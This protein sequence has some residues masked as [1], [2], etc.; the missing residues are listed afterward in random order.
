[1][2]GLV[3]YDAA[4][5]LQRDLA[6]QRSRNEIPDT[7]LL[8]EHPPTYTLGSKSE[9]RH[10]LAAKEW[11]AARR[12]AVH[13]VDRGGAIT[14]HGPGQLV[15]YPILQLKD[16]KEIIPYLRKLEEMV[17]RTLGSF[18]LQAGRE[19]SQAG[20]RPA[21]GVWINNEKVAA[22]GVKLD[23]NN[24]TSHGFAINV[25]TDLQYFEKIVPCGLSNRAVTSLDVCLGRPI[26]ME[27]VQS[28]VQ[29]AFSEIFDYELDA[30]NQA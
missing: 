1:M 27:L 28:R 20:Q 8:L 30:W 29:Q 26:G 7:L 4:L 9:E 15:G 19:Q 25:S 21:T 13:H 24:I 10:F 16:R 11:L 12:V 14:F 5:H 18:G 22:I 6:G 23:G 3:E 17:I 2:L